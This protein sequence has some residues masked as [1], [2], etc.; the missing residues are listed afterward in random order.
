MNGN[1]LLKRAL[2]LFEAVKTKVTGG[3]RIGETDAA[4]L[5]VA[6]MVSALDGNVSADE[7][8]AF[9]ELARLCRGCTDK[10]SERVFD[11]GLR[12]AG[13]LVLQAKLLDESRLVNAFVAEAVRTMP[14]GFALSDGGDVRRAFVMW[15]T[16][17]LSDGEFSPVERSALNALRT[18]LDAVM[19]SVNLYNESS[20][21][22][23]P[24]PLTHGLVLGGQPCRLAS[25]T[26]DAFMETV[27]SLVVR[28]R[29]EG[30]DGDA[31]HE[32]ESLILNG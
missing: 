21:V 32:L 28:M 8:A 20:V 23:S 10:E 13:Y 3:E 17:A 19:E 9:G 7:L 22:L 24:A 30:A 5:K 26:T 14:A 31:A 2:A 1:G 25:A 4:V 11:E 18:Q 6:M 27:E 15:V 29:D 12:L 16:M